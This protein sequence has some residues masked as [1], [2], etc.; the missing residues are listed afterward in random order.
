MLL[1]FASFYLE[2]EST[3]EDSWIFKQDDGSTLGWLFMKLGLHSL[4]RALGPE[5]LSKSI[6]LSLIVKSGE[7]VILL[8]G[9]DV[10]LLGNDDAGH[11]K[12]SRDMRE[13]IN[14]CELNEVDS[15]TPNSDDS[16]NPYNKLVRFL[17]HLQDFSPSLANF[18]IIIA[19]W[20]I[21]QRS[22]GS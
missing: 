8:G 7:E 21:S 19:F 3:T 6:W 1:V 9:N 4:F 10:S 14:L 2:N 22:F 17:L 13:L 12:L 15:S 5:L 18:D 20:A 11:H 16:G